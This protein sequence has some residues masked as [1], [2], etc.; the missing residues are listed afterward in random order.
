MLWQ[1]IQ[2]DLIRFGMQKAKSLVL[3]VEPQEIGDVDL[4]LDEQN[5]AAAVRLVLPG[6]TSTLSARSVRG[7]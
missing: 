5:G 3:E 6:R 2:T 7:L 1:S 4:V